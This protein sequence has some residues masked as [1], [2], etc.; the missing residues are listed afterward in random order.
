MAEQSQ[1]TQ[2]ISRN[3]QEY[4][5]INLVENKQNSINRIITKC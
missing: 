4:K 3:G 1:R 2:N 5:K